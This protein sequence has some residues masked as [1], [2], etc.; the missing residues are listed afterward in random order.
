MQT[1]LL[2]QFD[3]NQGLNQGIIAEGVASF[4]KKYG[5]KPLDPFIWKFLRMRPQNFPTIRLAQFA[6]LIIN[7][8]HLFSGKLCG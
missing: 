3:P 6:A 5:L 8:S 2:W 7:S 1:K 4:Y